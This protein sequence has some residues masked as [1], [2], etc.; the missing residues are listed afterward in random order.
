MCA[1]IPGTSV[2]SIFGLGV[3]VGLLVGYSI[4]HEDREDYSASARKFLKAVGPQGESRLTTQHALGENQIPDRLRV[5]RYVPL[6]RSPIDTSLKP[7]PVRG[8]RLNVPGRT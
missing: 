8:P 5:P 4:A 6:F 7:Y 2:L 3:V 1:T